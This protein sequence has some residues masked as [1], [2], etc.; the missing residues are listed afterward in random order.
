MNMWRR[1][2]GRFGLLR[3][4]LLVAGRRSSVDDP[5]GVHRWL[6][7]KPGSVC[8]EHQPADHDRRQPVPPRKPCQAATQVGK[9]RETVHS[10]RLP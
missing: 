8:A 4:G 7:P 6:G 9:E 1:L 2:I 5:R 10:Y 3:C